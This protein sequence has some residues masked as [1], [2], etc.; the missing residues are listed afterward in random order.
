MAK[1]KKSEADEPAD[2]K[3]IE[4]VAAEEAGNTEP[5]TDTSAQENTPVEEETVTEEVPTETPAEPES[6][7]PALKKKKEAPAKEVDSAESSDEYQKLV[8]AYTGPREAYGYVVDPNLVG[9]PHAKP[10]H[11]KYEHPNFTAYKRDVAAKLA[12]KE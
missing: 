1:K 7:E 5:S 10:V 11:R 6:P 4:T 8:D 2:A 12:A 3:P 9:K